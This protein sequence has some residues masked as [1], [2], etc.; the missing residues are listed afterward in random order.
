MRD[1]EILGVNRTHLFRVLTG[2]RISK[3]LTERYRALKAKQEGGEK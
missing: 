1:A 3:S 2:E